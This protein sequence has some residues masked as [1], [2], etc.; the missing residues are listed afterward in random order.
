MDSG[1]ERINAFRNGEIT[2]DVGRG[3]VPALGPAMDDHRPGSMG[4]R[5]GESRCAP[6]SQAR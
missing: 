1:L 2:I 5:L 3:P 4:R 6:H